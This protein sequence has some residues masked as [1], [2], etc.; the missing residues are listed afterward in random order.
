VLVCQRNFSKVWFIV[1]VYSKS[2]ILQRADSY[3]VLHSEL[4]WLLSLR[5]IELQCAAVCCSVLQR[6]AACYIVSWHDCYRSSWC[7]STIFARGKSNSELNEDFN[8]LTHAHTHT[9]THTR[10][11]THTRTCTHTVGCRTLCTVKW[12]TYSLLHLECHFFV[13]ES[14]SRIQFS[15]CVF[16]TFRWRET[17]EIE[18]GDWDS[19]TLQMQ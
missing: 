1:V 12:V 16:T 8:L 19:M 4:T 17:K 9:H 7:V 3:S 14:Q 6:V 10:T 13:L 5:H 18:N 2:W 11:R 15:R